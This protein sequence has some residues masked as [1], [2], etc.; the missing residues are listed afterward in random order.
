MHVDTKM[1]I[2]KN[3]KIELEEKNNKVENG[4]PKYQVGR[5]FIIHLCTETQHYSLFTG[6]AVKIKSGQLWF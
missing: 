4:L 1:Y 5:S 6:G 2:S 3:D